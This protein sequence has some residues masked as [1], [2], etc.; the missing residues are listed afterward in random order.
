MSAGWDYVS[1]LRPLTGQLFIPQ[2]IYMRVDS[3]GGMILT[4]ENWRT[5]RK[6]C[7]SAI[8]SIINPTWTNPD[9]NP[10]LHS[11]RPATNPLNHGTALKNQVYTIS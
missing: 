7:P 9:V 5:Q 4:G 6:T 11:E 2:M 8:M 3:C 1:E 10:G